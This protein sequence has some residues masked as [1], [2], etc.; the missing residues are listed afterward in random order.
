[1]MARTLREAT[2][3][4]QFALSVVVVFVASMVV[5]FVVHGTL[6]RE[7]YARLVPNVFRAPT[8]A[9]AHFIYML[10]GN[11]SMAIAITWIYRQGRDASPWLGQGL[12]FGLALVALLTIP[13]YLI[14][15]AVQPLPSDLVGQQIA[16]GGIGTVLLGIVTAAVNRGSAT[17]PTRA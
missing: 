11:L 16:Y 6:L 7:D 5:G 12:R 1:M 9:Q 17:A 13:M 15:F 2:M 14:Y 4:K 8:D 3:H 10:A